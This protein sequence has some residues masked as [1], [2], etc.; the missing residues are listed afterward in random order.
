MLAAI[1]FLTPAM[2]AGMGLV[3]LPIA[4]HLLNRRVRRRL[5]FP[6]I[7][8]LS[9]SSASTSRLYRLRRWL[10][11]ILRC[12]AVCLIAW[13]FA[14]PVWTDRPAH[15][16]GGSGA[17]A[18]VLLLDTSASTA[19]QSHGVSLVNSM[20]A[21]SER[22]LNAL[23]RGTDRV[24]VVYASARPRAAFPELSRN[25]EVIR[26]ELQQLKACQE[27]ADFREAV[28]VAGDLLR[29]RSDKGDPPPGKR[30]LV[31]LSDMQRTNWADVT[32]KGAGR[33]LPEG[34]VVTV[35]PVGSEAGG[36][37]GVSEPRAV[38]MQPIVGQPVQMVV[39]VT[40]HSPAERTVRV[41]ATANGQPIGA[42]DVPLEAWKGRHVA[43]ET[44]LNAPGVHRVVFSVGPDALAADNT[45]YLAARAVRRVPV[46]V[47]GDDN[48]HEPGT[49]SYFLIR[50]LAPHG[51]LRDDLEVRHL[52][53]GDLT[54]AAVSDAQALF[55]GYVGPLS[56][57]ALTALHMYANQGGGV[58]LCCGEG[59]VHENLLGLKRTARQGE[60]LPWN[61]GPARLLTDAGGFLQIERGAWSSLLL[62]DFDEESRDALRQV[63][64]RRVYSTGAAR[65][66]A[67]TLLTYGDGTP[68]LSEQALGA[69]KLLVCNFSPSLACSDL[70]KHG[71]FVA[72]MHSLFH[73]VR[74]TQK[75]YGRAIVGRPVVVP[76]PAQQGPVA[77]LKVL[78]PDDRPCPA[79][80][81]G[82]AG[83]LLVH[84][85]RPTLAGFYELQHD[86]RAVECVS[87]NLDPREGDL[88]RVDRKVLEE[89]LAG[90]R[91]ALDIRAA[92]DS[93]PVLQLRGRPMWPWFVLAAM[94]AVALE[95]LILC[96]WKR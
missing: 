73:Y 71:G 31:I 40:N 75:Q 34:T 4:A 62:K 67:V 87:V 48:P 56:P 59:P 68:A 61:P 89:H 80:V 50:A 85:P 46:V 82:E 51:D 28:A 24:G 96:V 12:L 69:G 74:P 94:A 37:V 8:L 32:L 66:G 33:V 3:A 57:A 90:E 15:A 10:I 17:A 58:V 7:R 72:L 26:Q 30:R 76:A 49:S 47:V 65:P 19:Q 79:E 13:A 77:A 60:V 53:A 35:L 23:E 21:L 64:F 54:Y 42:L 83:R 86:D 5:L 41:Q 2:L 92:G 38:P 29:G 20:R 9:E 45:A 95:L 39:R 11:L 1:S 6:T 55:V 78:A 22:T 16:A 70:G 93:G 27:R 36:N 52:T 18:V 44:V 43:F 63:R 81:T 14:R 91:I 25:F 84:L 88:R